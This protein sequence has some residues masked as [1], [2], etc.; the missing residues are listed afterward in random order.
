MMTVR[1]GLGNR[2]YAID[3][4][5]CSRALLRECNKSASGTRQVV[6][7][8]DR[9]VARLHLADLLTYLPQDSLVLTFAPGERSKSLR[10]VGRLFDQ[11]AE[12]RIERGAVIVTL[13]GGVAGDLGGFVAATWLRGVPFIQVPTTLLAAV[14][15]SVGGKTGVNLPAGKN[16]VGA[17]HQP[18]AV[19]VDTNFIKTLKYREFV[20]GLAESVKQAVVRDAGFFDWHR[21]QADAIVEREPKVISELIARNCTLKA[22]IVEQDEREAGL[23]AVLNYGHTIGH[24]I[25]HLLEYEL[26]HGECVGLGMLVENE[27][28]VA[29]GMLGRGTADAIRDLLQRFRLPAGLPRALAAEDVCAACRVDKK[30]RAGAIGFMLVSGL[31]APCRVA[32]VTNAEIA[33][34]LRVV[35]PR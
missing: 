22:A 11:L 7:I 12:A 27:I 21:S 20:S 25:E 5:P 14:D 6:V 34:A 26:R 15:A 2:G 30:V 35:Q 29:R 19:I 33:A 16:L 32:D 23:R 24:A 4:G 13:G 1:V 9:A 3:I 10:V 8:A 28:A 18:E 17:F 31:G